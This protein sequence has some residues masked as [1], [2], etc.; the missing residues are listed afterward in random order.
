MKLSFAVKLLCTIVEIDKQRHSNIQQTSY[1]WLLKPKYLQYKTD[2][3]SKSLKLN[4]VHDWFFW[5]KKIEIRGS[6]HVKKNIEKKGGIY[7]TYN[8]FK[9]IICKTV[10]LGENAWDLCDVFVFSGEIL[11]D[12]WMRKI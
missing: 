8:E 12:S 9:R 4:Q 6:L 7:R 1:R 5:A 3:T 2:L 11:V 10:I